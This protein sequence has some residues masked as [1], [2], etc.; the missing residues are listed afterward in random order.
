MPYVWK[1]LWPHC[2]RLYT[3][4]MMYHSTIVLLSYFSPSYLP[5]CGSLGSDLLFRCQMSGLA[6]RR[7]DPLRLFTKLIDISTYH[8]LAETYQYTDW[9]QLLAYTMHILIDYSCWHTLSTYWLITAV[10]RFA[11]ST[12]GIGE[13][14]KHPLNVLTILLYLVTEQKL[15]E[16]SLSLWCVDENTNSA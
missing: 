7:V 12:N 2:P 6:I 11:I 4:H 1:E 15:L 14:P 16:T 13:V 10:F 3:P 9:L 8:A 5:D